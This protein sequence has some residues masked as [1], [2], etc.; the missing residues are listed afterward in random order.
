MTTPLQIQTPQQELSEENLLEK[1]TPEERE[2]AASIAQSLDVTDTQSAIQYGAA[3]QAEISQFADAILREVRA[4][5]A[6]KAGELLTGLMLGVQ[7][8]D[9]DSLFN[10]SHFWEKIPILGNLL[11]RGRRFVARYE[12]ISA[13]IETIVENLERA[14]VQL[15]KDLS[16]LDQLHQKNGALLKELDVLIAAGAMKLEEVRA[17]LLPE[18][19]AQAENSQDPLDVQRHQDM[20][21]FVDRFER[22]VHDLR[23]SRMVALQALPQI[24]LIQHNDQLLVERIQESILHTIPLWKNQMV[25]AISLLRQKKVLQMQRQVTETTNELMRQN[26]GMLRE[27]STETAR[28]TQRGIVEIET[29][30]QVSADLVATLEETLRI[31]ADGREK[32]RQAERELLQLEAQLKQQ[33]AGLSEKKPL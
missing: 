10:E 3:C 7:S 20:V 16:L 1:L 6:G 25:I 19:K 4:R 8:L 14:R 23:T 29:L 32:R 22:R 26:A 21:R 27:G 11:D 12:R 2:R 24:R 30:R 13:Q 28:E 9:V 18:I 17:T 33:L 15:L 5:E 31:Q